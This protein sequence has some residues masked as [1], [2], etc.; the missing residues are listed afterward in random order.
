MRKNVFQFLFL[1]LL[2]N[3]GLAQ[4]VELGIQAGA[5]NYWGDLSPVLRFN[6]TNLCGGIFFR[7]NL[8]HTWALKTELNQYMVSGSDKNFDFNKNRN[9]SFFSPI[10]EGAVLMEF[11]YSKYG[12]YILHK[13]FTTYVYAGIAGFRFKPQTVLD[14][15]V[16]EL[17][18]YQTEGIVYN[19]F[20]LA[21]PFGLGAK[22]M[23]NNKFALEGQFGFRKTF[24]DYLD[25]VST[26]Y[27][28]VSSR[29]NDGGLIGATL[30]DRSIEI[31]GTPQYSK[32]YK[33]GSPE[34]KDWYMCATVSVSMRLHTKIKCARFY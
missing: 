12:S 3:I 33:R 32:N 24:T 34:Q 30:T 10:T 9:L 17:A 18:V 11:N 29:F 14:G 2:A 20:S 5:C 13:K 21:V 8:N 4:R 19:K 26:V 25:D 27:P 6:E 23:L 31:Y 16:Y 1:L 7:L 28:D 15:K 22:W